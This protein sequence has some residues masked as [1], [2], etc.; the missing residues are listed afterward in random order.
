MIP[1]L[2]AT[3]GGARERSFLAFETQASRYHKGVYQRKR[4]ELEG[5]MD[6]RLRALYQAQLSSAHKSGVARFGDAVTAAV[7]AG[8]KAGGLY[9]FADIVDGEK[10]RQLV[11]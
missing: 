2:G 3:G 9:E 5:K 8:Q 4:A 1:G 7:R 6:A 11:P 10:E